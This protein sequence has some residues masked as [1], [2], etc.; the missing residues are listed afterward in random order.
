MNWPVHN[1]KSRAAGH[2][3]WV[4]AGRTTGWCGTEPHEHCEACEA[5]FDAFTDLVAELVADKSDKTD[6]NG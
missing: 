3:M 1:R 5:F 4:I 6:D 2:R